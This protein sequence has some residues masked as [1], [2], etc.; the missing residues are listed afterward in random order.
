MQAVAADAAL[1]ALEAAS[2][3]SE[4]VVVR[5]HVNVPAPDPLANDE[6]QERYKMYNGTATPLLLINGRPLPG[7]AGGLSEAPL[8]YHRLRAGIEE[9]LKDKVDLR[10]EMSAQADSSGQIAIVVKATGLEKF[11][12]NARLQIVLV[13][14]KVDF[15]AG[16]GIR[17]HEMIARSMPAGVAGLAPVQGVL[18]FS[19]DVEVS[20]LKRQLSRQLAKAEVEAETP[21]EAKP[22]E[23]A[24]LHLVAFVQNAE[25]GEVFQAGSVPVTG[26]A[27]ASQPGGK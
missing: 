27:P 14:D 24:A 26:L 22:L 1:S 20:K 3:K 25:T 4:L 8:V 7:I 18:S 19:G 2:A 13:E 23:L 10:L 12:P 17:F 9:L 21:F 15:V 11:P 5:S 6:N 16:N